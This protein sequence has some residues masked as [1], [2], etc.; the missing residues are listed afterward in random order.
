MKSRAPWFSQSELF[1]HSD[2]VFET[3]REAFDGFGGGAL[4]RFFENCHAGEC[5]PPQKDAFQGAS[6]RVQVKSTATNSEKALPTQPPKP[7]KVFLW[8]PR[9]YRATSPGDSQG[10]R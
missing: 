7:P 3:G 2:C 8:S 6:Q 1:R 4:A 10:M 9:P 5:Y